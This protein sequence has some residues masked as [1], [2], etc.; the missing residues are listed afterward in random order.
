MARP[1]I[2]PYQLTQ[3]SPLG[4]RTPIMPVSPSVSTGTVSPGAAMAIA[5]ALAGAGYIYREE[6]AQL[7]QDIAMMP[8]EETIGKPSTITTAVK[9]KRKLSKANKA[10][11]KAM[12]ATKNNFKLATKIASKANPNTKSK[13][14]KGTSKVKKLARKIR[15][16]VWGRLR[17]KK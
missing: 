2:R 3:T 16:S 5:V 14:G 15:K 13:I 12:K 11:T 8:I 6:I 1:V 9:V 10:M 17:R 7:A 4:L